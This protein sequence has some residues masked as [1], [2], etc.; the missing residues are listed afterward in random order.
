MLPAI[1]GGGGIFKALKHHFHMSPNDFRQVSMSWKYTM[2]MRITKFVDKTGLAL[3][4]GSYPKGDSTRG[5][6]TQS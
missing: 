3:N 4:Y 5:S 2:E 1:L 6:L